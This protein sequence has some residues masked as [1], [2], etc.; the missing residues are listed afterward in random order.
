VDRRHGAPSDLRDTGYPGHVPDAV[1]GYCVE[2][3]IYIRRSIG[4][5]PPRKPF[6]NRRSLRY[7]RGRL[8]RDCGGRWH[9]AGR[10]RWS[11][12]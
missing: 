10:G 2:R 5:R 9:V 6:A 11:R 4:G 7:R 1:H 3:C 8:D 12:T